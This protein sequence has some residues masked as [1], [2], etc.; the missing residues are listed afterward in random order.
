VNFINSD[1]YNLSSKQVGAKG[2]NVK[3]SNLFFAKKHFHSFHAPTL[4]H[5]LPPPERFIPS[6]S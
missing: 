5:H 1:F 3:P 2:Y 6:T 4:F